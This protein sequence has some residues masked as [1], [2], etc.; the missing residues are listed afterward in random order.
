MQ[1]V[2]S[3][4]KEL[5][6]EKQ[7]REERI[8][9]IQVIQRKRGLLEQREELIAKLHL[10]EEKLE[11]DR[12][13]REQ[14]QRDEQT[15][16]I[17]EEKESLAR[18]LERERREF[19][20]EKEAL[21]AKRQRLEQNHEKKEEDWLRKASEKDEQLSAAKEEIRRHL[22]RIE[23]LKKELEGKFLCLVETKSCKITPRKRRSVNLFPKR[24][25]G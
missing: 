18:E 23:S 7:L 20:D 25:T 5:K 17:L 19:E 22:K 2:E 13:I 11:T 4:V 10:E 15:K 6:R 24:K 14:Q 16:I 8:R 1:D 3:R 9:Q 21:E 12:L